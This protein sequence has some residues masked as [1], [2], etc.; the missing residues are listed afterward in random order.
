LKI[1]WSYAPPSHVNSDRD[2]TQP[3][4]EQGELFRGCH[5]WNPYDSD[6]RCT[7]VV[8]VDWRLLVKREDPNGDLGKRVLS[9]TL[10]DEPQGKCSASWRCWGQARGPSLA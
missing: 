6:G 8:G 5:D 9:H 2:G 10:K 3:D 1:G 4:G 7:G